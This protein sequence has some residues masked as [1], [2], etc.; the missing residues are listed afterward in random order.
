MKK[1]TALITGI[2]GFAGS[3]L[4]EEL[5]RKGYRVIGTLAPQESTKNLATIKNELTLAKLDILNTAGCRKL[6][7]STKPD[8]LFHL[9]AIASVGK[10]FDLEQTTFRV[11]FDGTQNMLDAARQHTGLKKFLFVGSADAYGIFRPPTKTLTEN[12]CFNPISPYGIAKAAAE[13]ASRYYHRAHG[14]PVV[15]ARAFNHSGPRQNDNFVIPSFARQIALIEAG[16]QKPVLMVGD[17]SA[18]RDFSDVRDIVRGYRLLAE[19]G[20]PGE[21]YHLCSGK[22]VAINDLLKILLSLSSADIEVRIDK[23]RLRKADIPILRGSYAK[24]ARQVNFTGKIPLRKTL[25]D[26]LGYWRDLI[27]TQTLNNVGR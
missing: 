23:S 19:K 13:Y 18:R 14:L 12:Q 5:L 3:W 26:T 20:K 24:A 4:A 22:A 25:R 9:A 17:L 21:V 8:Y 1:P 11:N 16:H 7:I 10:S 6:V 2:A 15:V 27:A